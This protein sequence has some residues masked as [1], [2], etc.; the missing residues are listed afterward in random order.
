MSVHMIE[1]ERDGRWDVG[2]YTSEQLGRSPAAPR[3]VA[4]PLSPSPCPTS[5][6]SQSSI[7]L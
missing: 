7:C 3:A 6:P 1:P 5:S 2:T 4:L